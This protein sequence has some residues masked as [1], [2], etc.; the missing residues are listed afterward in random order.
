MTV[1]HCMQHFVQQWQWQ[2]RATPQ[3]EPN[4]WFWP[5]PLKANTASAMESTKLRILAF[6]FLWSFYPWNLMP[7]TIAKMLP[8]VSLSMAVYS[9]PQSCARQMYGTHVA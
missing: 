6:L 2:H 4:A 9:S 8:C 7:Q 3:N 1:Q 5:D